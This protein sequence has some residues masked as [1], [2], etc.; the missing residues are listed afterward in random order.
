MRETIEIVRLALQGERLTF[1]GQ[2]FQLPR[3]GGEGKA[4]RLALAPNPG[5]PIYLATLSPRM[6]ELTGEVADG[7][8][9]TSF[10]PEG[11]GAF[12][13]PLATGAARAGRTLA[14]LDLCQGGDVAF[15]DD[16]D[17][18]VAERK[19]R[20]A[21]SL[22]G[23]GSATTNFYND[24]YRRQGWAEAASLVQ[25]LWVEG[26]RQDAAAAVPDEM[27][28]KTTLIGTEAMVRDR[29]RAWRDAGITTLRVYPA[30]ATLDERLA[31][32]GRAI[33]VVTAVSR[34]A[35]PSSPAKPR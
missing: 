6:L 10:I 4:L 7:W 33:D 32:L 18:L 13:G 11:A 15:G 5:I 26:R 30:G 35:S 12:L 17:G 28:L 9:G 1:P 23:M 24:A 2:R 29:I 22:G 20:L 3:P 16:V 21:F 31:T 14:D 34:E 27:V 19:S 8:L 25:R